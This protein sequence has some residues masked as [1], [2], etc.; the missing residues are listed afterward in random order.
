MTSRQYLTDERLEAVLSLNLM[1]VNA[2]LNERSPI[3][4]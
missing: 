4:R 3:E 2:P 1:S